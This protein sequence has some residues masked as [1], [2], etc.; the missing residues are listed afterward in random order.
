MHL[1]AWRIWI[2]QMRIPRLF[3][4]MMCCGWAMGC[5]APVS[6]QEAGAPAGS[7]AQAV[8]EEDYEVIVEGIRRDRAMDAFLRGDF[9]T[10]EVEF[11]N[12]WR[13]IWRNERLFEAS[14]RH[15]ASDAISASLSPSGAGGFGDV[16]TPKIH[17]VPLRAD[18]IADRTCHSAEWQLYMVGLSQIQLGKFAEAKKS[19]Y[20]AARLSKEDLLFDAHY[21][22]GLLELLDGDIERAARRLTYLTRLQR[23]CK[24]RGTRCEIHADLDEATA[25]LKRAIAD[26]RKAH[27]G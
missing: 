13:C 15:A 7:G 26:A 6:A 14:V 8:T 1:T 18:E 11:Q 9:V 23:S 2:T 3:A 4:T 5:A 21:R 10:A 12:N 24:N 19:L 20:R 16:N 17:N 27:R 25:Y 22:I